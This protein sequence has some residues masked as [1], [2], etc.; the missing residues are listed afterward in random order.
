MTAKTTHVVGF[1]FFVPRSEIRV[2][3]V[4]HS[5]L[6]GRRTVRLYCI[7]R[8]LLCVCVCVFFFFWADNLPQVDLSWSG[9]STERFACVSFL[10]EVKPNNTRVCV[11]ARAGMY[12]SIIQ[13]QWFRRVRSFGKTRC[14]YIHDVKSIRA[15][16]CVC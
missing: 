7:V 2:F 6:R 8:Y 5:D 1:F 13:V 11:R 15:R 10:V 14:V 4:C 3:V 9:G 12:N 16:P